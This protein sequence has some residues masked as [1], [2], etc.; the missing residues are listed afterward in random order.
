MTDGPEKK[1]ERIS[2]ITAAVK[3]VIDSY[4]IGHEFYGNELKD[5]CLKL[6]PGFEDAYTDTFLKMARRHRRDSYIA[7]DH[8][9][10]LY[11][12]VKSNIEI[13]QEKIERERAEELARMER[14]K[15]PIKTG[16][17]SLP[18]AQG[19][20]GFFFGV[21]ER[22]FS[23]DF[24]FDGLPGGGTSLIASK[25]SS[26]YKA[27]CENGLRPALKSLFLTVARGKSSFFAISEIV[28]PVIPHIIG[29]LLYSFINVYEKRLLSIVIWI[30]N[31]C[32]I[33]ILD[34]IG[35]VFDTLTDKDFI[36]E[37]KSNRHWAK[38]T[39]RHTQSDWKYE[40][41]PNRWKLGLDYRIVVQTYG[42]KS[43]G[44]RYTIVDDFIIVCSNL[45]YPINPDDKPDYTEHQTEQKFHTIDGELA[46][47][48]RYYT[49]NKNAHLKINK[50]LL[51]KFN[52]EV[53]KIRKWMS[54]PDDVVEEFGV[55]KDEAARLWNSG[56]ALIGN[57]DVQL[58]EYKE[59]K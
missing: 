19:F 2:T 14:A 57:S 11:K 51:M 31:N 46:F 49:G 24:V 39:W 25:S 8:N 9:N 44:S 18:F 56:L 17:L 27:S 45:G 12:R 34:Q 13:L 16:Q 41:L 43:Y 54:D 21:S 37:Y 4:A 10:S 48:M 38:S 20:L 15:Q 58:L 59:A 28:I 52:I 36:T 22:A 7:I 35:E 47:T 40:K 50:R 1:A 42:Y 33:G 3:A 53:A 26:V 30:I 55:P 23:L 29:S 32:N 5:D 6:I